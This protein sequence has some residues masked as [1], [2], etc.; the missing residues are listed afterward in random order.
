M[1]H[2][3]LK[4]AE[5]DETDAHVSVLCARRPQ[6]QDCPFFAQKLGMMFRSRIDDLSLTCAK[7]KSPVLLTL[8]DRPIAVSTASAVQFF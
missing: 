8:G 4:T 2:L 1:S 3:T 5:Q 7:I 6:T